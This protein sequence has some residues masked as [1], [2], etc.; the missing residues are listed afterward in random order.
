MVSSADL[1]KIA[2]DIIV[3]HIEEPQIVSSIKIIRALAGI[4]INDD[5]SINIQ[6]L[7]KRHNKDENELKLFFAEK[8]I[9]L[10]DII[11]DD[12]E[13]LATVPDVIAKHIIEFWNN[14]INEQVKNIGI[15]PFS[16]VIELLHN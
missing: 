2:Y 4:D 14:H 12:S 13:L 7:C 8:G 1:R 9:T 5:K 11:S 6:K 10:D 15:I 16:L 3:R